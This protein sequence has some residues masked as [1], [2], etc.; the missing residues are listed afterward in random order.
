MKGQIAHTRWPQY[1][2]AKCAENTVEIA[3]QVNGRVR[4]R[5]T[6][7]ADIGKEE[8]IALAKAEPNVEKRACGQ[9]C[10]EKKFMCRA[11]W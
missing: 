5:V 9:N 10:G 11:S 2:E 6:V 3:V 8:A 7:A 1:D 4:A